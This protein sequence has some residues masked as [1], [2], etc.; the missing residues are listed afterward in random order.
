MRKA[1][2]TDARGAFPAGFHRAQRGFGAQ[3]LPRAAT[4]RSSRIVSRAG[5]F[6]SLPVSFVLLTLSSD[7]LSAGAIGD[8]VPLEARMVGFGIT[9]RLAIPVGVG[10]GVV[11]VL[12]PPRTM[13]SGE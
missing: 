5:P 2:P 7:S 12:L 4:R 10:V 9:G 11:V 8:P 13:T 6:A 3:R 1:V